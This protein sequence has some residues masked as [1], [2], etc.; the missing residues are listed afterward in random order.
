LLRIEQ[1][2]KEKAEVEAAMK[3]MVEKL[4]S[5]EAAEKAAAESAERAVAEDTKKNDGDADVVH[6]TVAASPKR[7]VEANEPKAE[8][9][10]Y[11]LC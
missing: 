2:E 1:L 4:A 7:D 3:Q 10:D 6:E 5:A 9:V 11:L 8:E